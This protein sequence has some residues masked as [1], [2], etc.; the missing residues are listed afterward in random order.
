MTAIVIL[1]YINYME[2]IQCIDSII[3]NQNQKGN[4]IVVDNGSKN[5]SIRHIKDIFLNEEIHYIQLEK[6]IGFAKGNNIGILK[7]IEL[8]A[9]NVILMNSDIVVQTSN[10]IDKLE[11]RYC[12][13]IGIINPL[14]I[15]IEGKVVR[16]SGIYSEKLT[17]ACVKTFLYYFWELIQHVFDFRHNFDG[18]T[19]FDDGVF[20]K[21]YMIQGCAYMLTKDFLDVYKGLYDKTFLYNEELNLA[22]YLKKASLKSVYSKDVV[23]LHKEGK[24]TYKKSRIKWA[25]IK[26]CRELHSFINS[27]PNYIKWN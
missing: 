1:N 24:S 8:G 27:I 3:Q 6:N 19:D 7:A 10:F 25:L 16:P 21:G 17:K 9:E 20:Q 26:F 4:I 14:C 5:D 2:T 12:K 22:W 23:F 18:N 15:D 11:I 13:G